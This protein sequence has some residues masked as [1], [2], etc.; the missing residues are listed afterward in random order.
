MSRSVTGS[1]G[2]IELFTSLC[3]I[4]YQFIS[5]SLQGSWGLGSMILGPARF[6]TALRGL[7][8]EEKCLMKLFSGLTLSILSI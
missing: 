6:I 1:N 2:T 7:V 8:G 3:M 4:Q 5:P